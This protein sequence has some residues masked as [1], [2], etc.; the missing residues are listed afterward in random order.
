MISARKMLDAKNSQ[1][2][3]FK[4]GNSVKWT[5]VDNNISNNVG[6]MELT[7]TKKQNKI[8]NRGDKLRYGPQ[9]QV[10]VLQIPMNIRGS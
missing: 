2:I 10:L 5:D 9:G 1:M 7:S 6:A 8:S 4:E 3:Y